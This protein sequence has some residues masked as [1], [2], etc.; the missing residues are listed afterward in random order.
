MVYNFSH[1]CFITLAI[2]VQLQLLQ[3]H[4]FSYGYTTS[5]DIVSLL[6]YRYT[7][8][9]VEFHYVSYGYSMNVIGYWIHNV[10]IYHSKSRFETYP[11]VSTVSHNFVNDL[12]GESDDL[13][14]T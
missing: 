13:R 1:C 12:S 6:S 4:Y 9:A 2:S 8:S 11:D 10:F 7:I 5:G 14:V 3:C